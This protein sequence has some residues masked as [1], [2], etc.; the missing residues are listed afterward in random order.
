VRDKLDLREVNGYSCHTTTFHPSLSP[1]LSPACPI[2]NNTTPDGEASASPP[3]DDKPIRC[4]VYIGTPQNPQFCGPEDPRRLAELI[5]NSVGP[6]GLNKEYLLELEK[7]LLELCT[8]H[9]D[10]HVTDLARM[11]REIE[12]ELVQ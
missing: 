8:E 9:G 3:R 2:N 7:G 5:A 12:A 1:D 11:V 6:S 4:L 10:T